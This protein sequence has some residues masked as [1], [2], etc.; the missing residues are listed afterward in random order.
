MRSAMSYTLRRARSLCRYPCNSGTKRAAGAKKSQS[1]QRPSGPDQLGTRYAFTTSKIAVGGEDWKRRL[2]SIG[3]G[4]DRVDV[5]GF[6]RT[7]RFYSQTVEPYQSLCA[8]YGLDSNKPLAIFFHSPVDE[9]YRLTCHPMQ[10]VRDV[11]AAFH[12]SAPNWNLLVLNH[13]RVPM[14]RLE[15]LRSEIPPSVRIGRAEDRF[16][17]LCQ[18]TS[19]IL[20]VLSAALTEATLAR[21]PII[22]LDYVLA[23]TFNR[24]LVSLG[25][26]VPVFHRSHLRE[27]IERAIHDRAFVARL[28][29]NQEVASRELLGLFDGKCA[30]RAA[31]GLK[32]MTEINETNG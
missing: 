16:W 27:Q 11:I 14:S 32:K 28:I 24:T 29:A 18:A 12:A 4:S 1:P 13:P 5:T 23:D 25:A 15:S 19:L 2:L 17:F 30:Q 31:L 10:P 9:C 3:I 21:K 20:G 7:D 8:H 26:V 22:S 6:L